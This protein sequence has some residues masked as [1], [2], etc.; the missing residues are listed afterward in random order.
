MLILRKVSFTQIALTVLRLGVCCCFLLLSLSFAQF[1]SLI[2]AHQTR[3]PV[4]FG[5]HRGKVRHVHALVARSLFSGPHFVALDPLV[6]IASFAYNAYRGIVDTGIYTGLDLLPSF[7]GRH[8]IAQSRC[9]V[10]HGIHK[11]HLQYVGGF[12]VLNL[13]MD[14]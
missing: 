5:F 10:L 3:S 8:G 11:V 1:E 12:G 2:N 13:K 7:V 14:T 6:F 4:G 9:R